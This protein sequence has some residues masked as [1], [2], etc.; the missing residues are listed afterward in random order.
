MGNAGAVCVGEDDH[1]AVADM[2][3]DIIQHVCQQEPGAISCP[4]TYGA[5]RD[6]AQNTHSTLDSGLVSIVV[7]EHGDN[8][9]GEFPQW[10]DDQRGHEISGKQHE[11]AL[12]F[13]KERNCTPQVV[14]MVVSV[15]EYA[16]AHEL[17]LE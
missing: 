3:T 4:V 1:V 10:R 14:D 17:A 2:V 7:T 16:H 15:R 13:I 11:P 8:R 9:A 5:G 6:T 12:C